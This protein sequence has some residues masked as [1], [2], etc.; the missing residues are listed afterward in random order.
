MINTGQVN[1]QGFMHISILYNEGMIEAGDM[2][3]QSFMECT[4]TIHC[5]GQFSNGELP[6]AGAGSTLNGGVIRTNDFI[7]IAGS[8]LQGLG[9]ICIIG[10]SENHGYIGPM[11]VCDASLDVVARHHA[12]GAV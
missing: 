9:T 3:V 5:T 8:T 10:Q 11:V 2:E 6:G 1:T 7:N 4:G 12:D